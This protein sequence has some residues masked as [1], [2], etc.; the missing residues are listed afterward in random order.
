M[1]LFKWCGNSWKYWCSVEQLECSVDQNGWEQLRILFF[2]AVGSSW[3]YYCSR[4]VVNGWEH[5]CSMEQS[6]YPED[7][8][9][10]GV[11]VFKVGNTS[12]TITVRL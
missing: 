5:W 11:G 4:G 2:Q 7:K 6:E 1:L 10:L 9:V 8:N 12:A 3:E